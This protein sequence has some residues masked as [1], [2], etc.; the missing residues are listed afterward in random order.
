MSLTLLAL[1]AIVAAGVLYTQFDFNPAVVQ[2]QQQIDS[3]SDGSV[4]EQASS[5]RTLVALPEQLTSLTPL[6]TFDPPTLS[7]KI[8]GKAELYLASGFVRLESQRFSPRGQPQAWLEMFAYDMGKFENAYSV[9]SVQRRDNAAGIDL[10]EYAYQTD[11]ALFL[12]HGPYYLEIIASEPTEEM[13]TSMELLAKE[14]IGQTQVAQEAISENQL[15]PKENLIADSV[16][17]IPAN[18]FG[19][20]R[21]D[22][23]FTAVYRIEDSEITAFLSHRESAAE[24]VELAEAYRQFLIQF[25]GEAQKVDLSI[26][27]AAVV[28][29]LDSFEIV[30]AVGPYFAGV[31]EA[32]DPQQAATLAVKLYQRLKTVRDDAGS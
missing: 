23:V 32:A 22:K 21:L 10:V 7:D 3:G 12:V 1:I 5:E 6:E 15:F 19:H 17:R 26:E 30:F 25:G 4:P 31:R 18:A 27:N 13:R 2:W 11:N 16:A 8:N 20:E 24:A 28:N 29:I 14:F 9:F